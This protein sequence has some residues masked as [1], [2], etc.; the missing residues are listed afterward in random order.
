MNNCSTCGK[1]IETNRFVLPQ[2]VFSGEYENEDEGFTPIV[3]ILPSIAV[4]CGECQ[5]KSA[6]LLGMLSEITGND[7][8]V[9]A[10]T[11]NQRKEK[12]NESN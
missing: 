6:M 8:G 9:I 12:S 11:V 4:M 2:M 5:A 1:E 3:K 7:I 10:R